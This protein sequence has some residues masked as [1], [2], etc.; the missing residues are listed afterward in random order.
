MWWRWAPSLPRRCRCW[1]GA[2]PGPG[3]G[4]RPR[5]PALPAAVRAR[6]AAGAVRPG[7]AAGAGRRGERRRRANPIVGRANVRPGPLAPAA[8]DGGDTRARVRAESGGGGC[9][10]RPQPGGLLV[11]PLAAAGGRPH[12]GWRPA[13][14][15]HG[16]RRAGTGLR[17]VGSG[18]A[19]PRPARGAPGV[20]GRSGRLVT[21]L[22]RAAPGVSRARLTG[23]RAHGLTPNRAA[24]AAWSWGRARSLTSTASRPPGL[25]PPPVSGSAHRTRNRP[26]SPGRLPA[27]PRSRPAA[28]GVRQR[29]VAASELPRSRS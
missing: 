8:A 1:A 19:T 9:A 16:A 26:P 28:P 14:W 23:S 4:D 7:A 20:A 22:R 3:R 13:R 15:G 18:A 25:P 29:D 12:R 11:R 21:A 5:W 17:C 10:A 24:L 27:A 6:A 2:S